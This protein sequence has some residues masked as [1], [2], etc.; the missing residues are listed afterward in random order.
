MQ[1]SDNFLRIKR[2]ALVFTGA[3]YLSLIA[4]IQP[5]DSSLFPFKLE[6]PTLIKEFLLCLVIF[7]GIQLSL[8]WSSQDTNIKNSK[9]FKVDYLFSL[10][11][12]ISSILFYILVRSRE[13]FNT[14]TVKDIEIDYINNLVQFFSADYLSIIAVIIGAIVSILTSQLA[15]LIPKYIKSRQIALNAELSTILEDNYWT[16]IFNPKTPTG[17]K[18][19]EFRSEFDQTLTRFQVGEGQ[20]KN[21]NSWR[22]VNGLLEIYNDNGEI[23]SRFRYEK[24]DN[25]FIHTNDEDTISIR[26]QRIV[27]REL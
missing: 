5:S 1:P 8:Y 19:I 12:I 16:L 2:S 27:P 6:D 22:V 11:I 20:N 14:I 17:R 25:T 18:N 24:N 23:F 26:D 7:F 3:L 10:V 21:E 15:N 13:F 9:F 4:G